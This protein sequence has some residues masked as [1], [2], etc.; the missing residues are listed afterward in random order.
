MRDLQKILLLDWCQQENIAL[1]FKKEPIDKKK[2]NKVIPHLEEIEVLTSLSNIIQ[3]IDEK[4][5]SGL[6]KYSNHSSILEGN[7]NPDFLI[8]NDFTNSIEQDSKTN[9]LSSDE[10]ELLEKMLNAIDINL[11]HNSIMNI[12]FWRT[13]GNRNPTEDEIEDCMPAVK[14]LVEIL[15]PKYIITLGDLALTSIMERNCNLMDSR[16]KKLNCKYSSTPVFALFHPRLLI[17]QP[18]L[19]RLAWEDLKFIKENINKNKNGNYS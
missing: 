1:S 10:R 13:P 12:F 2:Q 19:K 18:S 5:L 15:A 4:P 14:R 17:K 3:Y 7:S 8:V 16:G 9:I 11:N 6:K